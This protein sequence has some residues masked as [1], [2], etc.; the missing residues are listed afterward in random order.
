LQRGEIPQRR[1]R[2]EDD[3]AAVAAVAAVGAALRDVLLAA[4][5]QAAVAAATGL[6]VK[7]CAVGERGR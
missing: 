5:R 6:Q 1:V 3:V 7:L 4:E 2:D